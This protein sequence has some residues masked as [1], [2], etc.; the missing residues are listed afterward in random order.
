MKSVNLKKTIPGFIGILI[1]AGMAIQSFA[2]NI[3]MAAFVNREKY[4]T[5]LHE[6]EFRIDDIDKELD[7]LYKYTCTNIRT[8]GG[9]YWAGNASDFNYLY[10]PSY[11]VTAATNYFQHGHMLD[12]SQDKY[13]RFNQ[14]AIL[15]CWGDLYNASKTLRKFEGSIPAS[16]CLWKE[17]IEPAPDA[18]VIWR[19]T[20]N[21]ITNDSYTME[22]VM[23]PFKKFPKITSPGTQTSQG[24]ICEVPF[25]FWGET[26]SSGTFSYAIGSKT[27]PTSWTTESSSKLD[28][29]NS[30]SAETNYSWMEPRT[31]V[32]RNGGFYKEAVQNRSQKFRIV[33]AAFNA[34]D[35]K[36]N[37]WLRISFS[38]SQIFDSRTTRL[39]SSFVNLTNWNVKE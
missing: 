23:G 27:E 24:L 4:L 25:A 17:G 28:I 6:L 5:K 15:N 14:V 34:L 21:G 10:N 35:G 9:S 11:G 19:G 16:R 32:D 31:D 8:L 12:I 1:I 2:T 29:N 30:T 37:T 13:L 26:I 36:E 3:D 20:I 38:G 39:H 22:F 7:R 18:K 33:T